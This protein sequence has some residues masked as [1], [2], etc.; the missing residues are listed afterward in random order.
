MYFV[1]WTCPL[2]QPSNDGILA[3][4]FG[5]EMKEVWFQTSSGLYI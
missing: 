2:K 3:E 5:S 1:R 4:F